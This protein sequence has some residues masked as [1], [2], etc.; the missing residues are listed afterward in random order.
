MEPELVPRRR[1][2]GRVPVRRPGSP[3]PAPPFSGTRRRR[4]TLLADQD[5][6]SRGGSGAEACP[7]A[8]RVPCALRG[9]PSSER[10]KVLGLCGFSSSGALAAGE[11]EVAAMRY[12][13]S[14]SRPDVAAQLLALPW[15]LRALRLHRRPGSRWLPPAADAAALV[16]AGA[17][18]ALCAGEARGLA[19]SLP[20]ALV[21]PPPPPPGAACWAL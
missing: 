13:E 10:R 14:R 5:P 9:A 12:A 8:T 7:T 21:P 18:R 1:G 15:F 4:L 20:P 19:L 16:A 17:L 11:G 3:D 6:S 2:G